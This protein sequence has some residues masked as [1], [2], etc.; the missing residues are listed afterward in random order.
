MKKRIHFISQVL[1][2]IFFT[3]TVVIDYFPHIG[4][5]KSIGI[6]G[7]IIFTVMAVLTRQQG[8]PVFKTSK[9]EF[10]FAILSGMYF[11]SLILILSLLGGVSQVGIGLD[12]PIIWGLYLLGVL[13]FYIK[14][15]RGKIQN[16]KSEEYN[17]F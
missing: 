3:L 17:R 4:I 16:N 5:N 14:Y 13:S 6:T 10:K 8:E 12:N 9:S 11:F 1:F 7:I 2:V 15:R